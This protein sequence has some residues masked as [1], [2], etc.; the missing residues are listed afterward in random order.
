MF[1]I[2]IIRFTLLLLLLPSALAVVSD[3]SRGYTYSHEVN[4]ALR[5]RQV[6]QSPIVSSI[7]YNGT[8]PLR[9][10]IRE[11]EKSQAQWTLYILA[12]SWMQYMNQTDPYSWY[13]LAG[14]LA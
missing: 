12:L 14:M 13:G 6:N 10:E 5:K 8:I 1:L 3:G 2:K 9:M 7:P 11:L 4:H